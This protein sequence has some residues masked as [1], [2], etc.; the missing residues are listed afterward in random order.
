METKMGNELGE[1]ERKKFRDK[2]KGRKEKK[3]RTLEGTSGIH[4]SK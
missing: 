4:L 2:L 3:K 1:V